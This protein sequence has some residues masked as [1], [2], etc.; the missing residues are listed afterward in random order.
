VQTQ[1]QKQVQEKK[2]EYPPELKVL[3]YILAVILIIFFST[4]ILHRFFAD[5][6]LRNGVLCRDSAQEWDTAI[7]YY[8]KAL[9][10]EPTNIEVPYKLAY[11]YA[12]KKEW[13]KA[14]DAYYSIVR[15]APDYTQIHY[16]LGITYY[17]LGRLDLAIQEFEKTVKID[18]SNDVGFFMLGVCY[19]AN[20]EWD[21]AI[22]AFKC[23]V[24]A[25]RSSSVYIDSQ[26]L[27]Y[28][29]ANF[30]LGNV[31]YRLGNLPEAAT[32]YETV[33]KLEPNNPDA[34]MRLQSVRS[35]RMMKWD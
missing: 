27:Y 10:Y 15:L 1:V 9:Q 32:Q 26:S 6:N 20:K 11:I 17:N 24:A 23:A 7:G 25:R 18:W 12:Q 5:I 22:W 3:G 33:L 29:A 4:Q 2:T 34:L 35:G 30:N 14:L 21:K 19:S 31:Y 16:N 28:P 8:Q 13:N